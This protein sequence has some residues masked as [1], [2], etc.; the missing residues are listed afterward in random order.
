VPPTCD[1]DF[2]ITSTMKVKYFYN[3]HDTLASGPQAVAVFLHL[4]STVSLV[5]HDQN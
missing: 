4:A 3:L 5:A 1:R 2:S